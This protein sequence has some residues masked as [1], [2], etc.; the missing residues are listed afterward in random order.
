MDFDL[1]DWAKTEADTFVEHNPI[2]FYLKE[3][4]FKAL[5]VIEAEMKELQGEPDLDWEFWIKDFINELKR[6]GEDGK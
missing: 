4:F 5:E 1:K 2:E 6:G 3:G